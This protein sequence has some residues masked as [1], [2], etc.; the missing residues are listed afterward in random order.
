VKLTGASSRYIN[1]PDEFDGVHP[2]GDDDDH[3]DIGR[4]VIARWYNQIAIPP[5]GR[6]RAVFS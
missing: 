5:P 4:A 3:Y 1:T 2:R 6:S